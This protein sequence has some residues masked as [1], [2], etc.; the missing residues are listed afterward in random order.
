MK[1]KCINEFEIQMCD[2]DCFMIDNDYRNVPAGSIWEVSESNLL[3]GEV[4]L[5]CIS[6][7]DDFGWIEITNEHLEENF[8]EEI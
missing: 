5:V 3:G 7:C 1:Y 6:G 4:H 8:M 2:D